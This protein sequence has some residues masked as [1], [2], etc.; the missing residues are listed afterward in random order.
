MK[1]IC[2]TALLSVLGMT[3][4]HA[5]QVTQLHSKYHQ[6]D[7]QLTLTAV[8]AAPLTR[9]QAV[10]RD[11]AK[12]P[13]LDPRIVQAEVLPGSAASQLELMTRIKVC[14]AFLCRTI[15]RVERVSEQGNVLLAE[16]IAARSDAERGSTRTELLAQ[17]EQTLLRYTTSITPKFWV[18]AWVGRAWLLRS[19]EQATLELFTRIEQ[20]AG[21]P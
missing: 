8:L 15:E 10:L 7:Y 16:V 21:M 19:L 18:P 2:Q 20:R 5:M 13:E 17:G 3:Q 12:Y 4:L 9:V 14:F 11:Y 6:G 1:R